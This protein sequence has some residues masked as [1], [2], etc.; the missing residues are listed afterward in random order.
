MSN[1]K[2]EKYE[3]RQWCIICGEPRGNCKHVIAFTS[4]INEAYRLWQLEVKRKKEEG[5]QCGPFNKG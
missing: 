2:V 1:L 3:K 4:N 5:L